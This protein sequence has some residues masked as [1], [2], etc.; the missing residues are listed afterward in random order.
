MTFSAGYHRSAGPEVNRECHTVR[1]VP[2][3]IV[4]KS[5]IQDLS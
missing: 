3:L 1:V 5:V 2:E 4:G